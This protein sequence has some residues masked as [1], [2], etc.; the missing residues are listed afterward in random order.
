VLKPVPETVELAESV[1]NAPVFALVAPTVPL[2][3]PA[4]P[5]AVTTPV[6]LAKVNADEA[7]KELPPLLY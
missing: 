6:P 4:K 1:V 5:V 3:A 2:S 7:P